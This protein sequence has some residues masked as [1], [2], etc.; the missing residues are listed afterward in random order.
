MV[1]SLKVD[2]LVGKPLVIELEVCV[3]TLVR[4]EGIETYEVIAIQTCGSIHELL[5]KCKD[6]LLLHCDRTIDL[7]LKTNSMVEFVIHVGGRHLVVLHFG[8]PVDFS[9]PLTRKELQ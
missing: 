1:H 4:S 2:N 9:S 8:C 6:R 3:I 7:I 5:L